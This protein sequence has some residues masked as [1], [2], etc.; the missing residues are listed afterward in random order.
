MAKSVA[1]LWME[2]SM[3]PAGKLLKAYDWHV[4]EM[5]EDVGWLTREQ[6]ECNSAEGQEDISL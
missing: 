6:A 2:A 1:K 5:A 4:V 3:K